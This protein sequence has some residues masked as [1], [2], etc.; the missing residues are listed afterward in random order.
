MKIHTIKY[1]SYHIQQQ[2]FLE[3][4]SIVQLITLLTSFLHQNF[5]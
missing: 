1:Y 2:Y 5:D 3:I 4:F